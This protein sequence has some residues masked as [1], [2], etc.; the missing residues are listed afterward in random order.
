MDAFR[1]GD[2]AEGVI[3][4]KKSGPCS[5]VTL[6]GKYKIEVFRKGVLVDIREGEN[7]IVNEGLDHALDVIFNAAAELSEWKIGLTNDPATLAAADTMASHGG[8]TEN[9]AYSETVR[10]DWLPGAASS[11]SITNGSA[12]TFTMTGSATLAGIFV[13]SSGTKGGTTGTL[14]ATANFASAL[15]VVATDVVKITYTVN[16]T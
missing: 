14:W 10:Q 2:H 5:P 13:T 16:A 6:R 12:A 1:F 4:K 7:M 9:T 11:Q 15:S 3:E 8:W